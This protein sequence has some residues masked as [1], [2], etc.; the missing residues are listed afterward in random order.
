MLQWFAGRAYVWY[1]VHHEN[2]NE[3][4]DHVYGVKR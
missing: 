1:N 4:D 3:E 2:D